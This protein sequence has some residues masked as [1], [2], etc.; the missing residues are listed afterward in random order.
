MDYV[1]YTDE[2]WFHQSGYINAQNFCIRFSENLH[3]F[4]ETC[5]QKIGVWCAISGR[6]VVGPILFTR[7]VTGEVYR[8]IITNLMFLHHKDEKHC[9][10][11]Q[12][13]VTA[14]IANKTMRFLYEFFDNRIVRWALWPARSPVLSSLDFFLWG[15]LKNEVYKNN[16]KIITDLK[17]N[18]QGK[19]EKTE[20][21]MPYRVATNMKKGI[22]GYQQTNDGYFQ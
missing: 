11:Q 3:G 6:R 21:A 18:I 20:S 16:P 4:Q 12:D 17:K 13:G 2:A 9:W 1:F 15:H 19:I 8:E 10:L 22:L 14:Y 5:L 7:F